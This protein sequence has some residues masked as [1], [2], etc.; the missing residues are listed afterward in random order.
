MRSSVARS[1]AGTASSRRR[2]LAMWSVKA[3]SMSESAVG[4]RATRRTRS[5]VASARPRDEAGRLEAVEPF[6]HAAGGH[7]GVLGELARRQLERRSGATQRGEHVELALA[8]AVLAVD[9]D[10]LGAQAVGEPVEA[11]DDALRRRVE[12]GTLAAPLGLDA[13]DPI[14]THAGIVPSRK[15]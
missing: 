10:E 13:V 12:V 9:G 14:F 7:H 1:D 3:A 6:G 11:A 8:E 4:V 15:L 2:S 5:S